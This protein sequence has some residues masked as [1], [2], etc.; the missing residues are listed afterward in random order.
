MTKMSYLTYFCDLNRQNRQNRW[1]CNLSRKQTLS[2][3]DPN[4]IFLSTHMSRALL[5]LI[6]LINLGSYF[7]EGTTQAPGVTMEDLSS[8][9]RI[10]FF[11]LFVDVDRPRAAAAWRLTGF[12][13]CKGSGDAVA[14]TPP[15]CSAGPETTHWRDHRS[16]SMVD[17]IEKK[18]VG[19]GENGFRI[20]FGLFCFRF[21]VP[22]RP[23][24]LVVVVVVGEKQVSSETETAR[25]RGHEGIRHF[26]D[27]LFALSLEVMV[28][29]P[30][31]AVPLLS[32]SRT[33][34]AACFFSTF[35]HALLPL[36]PSP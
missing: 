9:Q 16:L 32:T 18:M 20:D 24:L 29:F 14:T 5:I 23:F 3:R 15:T 2:I 25:K 7:G 36:R 26:R 28:H 8:R 10:S 17:Y 11:S 31:S 21:A 27:P 35:N 1:R 22:R 4:V 6:T 34:L 33:E 13:V 19:T 30:A 12:D